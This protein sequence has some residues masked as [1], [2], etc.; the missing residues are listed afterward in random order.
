MQS[1]A[2]CGAGWTSTLKVPCVL[3]P[4]QGSFGFLLLSLTG[5]KVSGMLEPLFG[6]SG[7]APA[8]GAMGRLGGC[9]R[10]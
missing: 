2:C 10:D 1:V 3:N 6:T 8:N 5:G 4:K 9:A 7:S